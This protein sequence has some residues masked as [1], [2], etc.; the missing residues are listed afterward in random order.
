MGV[1]V[2]LVVGGDDR[3]FIKGLVWA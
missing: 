1:K 3:G 2:H